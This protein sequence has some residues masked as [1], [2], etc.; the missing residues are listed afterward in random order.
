MFYLRPTK[1]QVESRLNTILKK[2][3]LE[4][5]INTEAIEDE[6]NRLL[7]L[8]VREKNENYKHNLNSTIDYL[9]TL[10]KYSEKFKDKTTGKLKITYTIS[11]DKLRSTPI[12][13]KKIPLF[14]LETSDYIN[15][16]N[17]ILI[18]VNYTRL[19]N[20][21]AFRYVYED[22]GYNLDDIEQKLEDVN[23]VITH[24]ED[25]FNKII[26]S[27]L[28]YKTMKNFK[29]EFCPWMHPNKKE[30]Y[31]FFNDKIKNTS[32]KYTELIEYTAKKFMLLI[33]GNMLEE[34]IRLKDKISLV[35]IYEDGFKLLVY[36]E[37]DLNNV[38][39]YINCGTGIELFGRFF[40]Y[41]PDIKIIR[42]SKGVT[43]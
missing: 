4:V 15:I 23:M 25:K 41:K 11:G 37:T 28:K 34:L 33:V 10:K 21:M 20:A 6:I 38:L 18:D 19:I 36:D 8:D 22:L 29:I 1:N 2:F 7:D 9:E 17:G 40:R 13:F 26:D 24:D 12:E 32:G 27:D 43:I 5:G 35:G 42:S 3:V 31:S 39:D 30:I 16:E 14:N